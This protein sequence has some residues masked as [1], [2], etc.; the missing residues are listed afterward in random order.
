MLSSYCCAV[1]VQRRGR[2]A[3]E[4]A[5]IK[6]QLLHV[7]EAQEQILAEPALEAVFDLVVEGML[8]SAAAGVELLAIQEVRRQVAGS[9][10][11]VCLE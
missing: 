11:R 2:L 1:L 8:R 7:R 3:N 6:R 4:A 5:E 9:C 10:R